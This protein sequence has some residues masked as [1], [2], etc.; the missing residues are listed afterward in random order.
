VV[1]NLI[2]SARQENVFA[3][4]FSRDDFGAGK[5]SVPRAIA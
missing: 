3:G 5:V 2:A 4:A 1:A